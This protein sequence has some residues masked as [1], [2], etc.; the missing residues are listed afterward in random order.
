M[1]LYLFTANEFIVHKGDL[2]IEMYFITQGRIDVYANDD[3]KKATGSL[4][5]GGHFGIFDCPILNYQS[6]RVWSCLGTSS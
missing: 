6:R 3:S 2:G 5:E 1:R 4:I